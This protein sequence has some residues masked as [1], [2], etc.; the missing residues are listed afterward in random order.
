[1]MDI[2]IQKIFQKFKAL[3]LLLLLLHLILSTFF[4][5]YCHILLAHSVALLRH[6][7]FFDR[8]VLCV[9]FTHN[10]MNSVEDG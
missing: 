9:R 10:V 1:M 8:A 5:E 7:N 2:G 4:S 3:V 6:R